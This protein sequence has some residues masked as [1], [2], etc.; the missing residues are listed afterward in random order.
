MI[1]PLSI[2]QLQMR[3]NLRSGRAACALMR[4]MK[5]VREGKRMWTTEGW[6]AEWLATRAIP[7]TDLPTKAVNFDPL[8][9]LVVDE[10]VSLIGTLAEEGKIRVIAV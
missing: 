2:E 4:R 6:V 3:F 1:Q 10:V 7:S 8:R 5:H 9:R